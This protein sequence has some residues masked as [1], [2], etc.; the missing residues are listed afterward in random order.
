[1][2]TGMSLPRR[3]AARCVPLTMHSNVPLISVYQMIYPLPSPTRPNLHRHTL[4]P[5]FGLT[6]AP[7]AHQCTLAVPAPPQH[8]LTHD[9]TPGALTTPS[10]P[11]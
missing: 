9:D 5:T 2:L 10:S 3:S 1:M 6:H 7:H 11:P 4:Q 8:I